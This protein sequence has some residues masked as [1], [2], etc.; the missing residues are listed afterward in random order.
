MPEI[1]STTLYEKVGR[2]YRPVAVEIVYNSW[3]KGQ[4]LVIVNPGI[5]TI[6]FNCPTDK[7]AVLA[8]T[9]EERENLTKLLTE[10]TKPTGNKPI[11]PAAWQ[12][13]LNNGGPE[14]VVLTYKCAHDIVD[15]FISHLAS[16]I[17]ENP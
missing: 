6:Y 5:K 16:T 1:D 13:Y 3:P 4:H 8:A 15:A 14:G 7:A 12:A 9:I 2:R 17:K 10:A 11:P